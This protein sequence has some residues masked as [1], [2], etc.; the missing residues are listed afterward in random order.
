MA[1]SLNARRLERS[2]G[3]GPSGEQTLTITKIK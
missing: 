2:F 3:N 1:Q